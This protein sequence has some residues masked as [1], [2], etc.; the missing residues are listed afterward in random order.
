MTKVTVPENYNFS[1][2]KIVKPV[3]LDSV[4]PLIK[5]AD[6]K[7][8]EIQRN[9]SKMTGFFIKLLSKLTKIFETNGDHKDGKLEAIQ[10]IL[11]GI[12]MSVHATQNLA[13]IRKKES[14]YLV[15]AVNTRIWL[16]LLRTL[17]LIFLGRN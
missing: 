9:I 7:L 15:L 1:Q 13:S 10:T 11:G 14:Y 3:V 17:T 4:S 5:S 6:I 16:S 2:E 8:Q 12:K